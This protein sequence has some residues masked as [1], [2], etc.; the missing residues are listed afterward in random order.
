MKT[1]TEQELRDA[2]QKGA[3]DFSNSNNVP[4]IAEG[5]D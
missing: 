2:Y 5:G 4:S 1:Y 3:I